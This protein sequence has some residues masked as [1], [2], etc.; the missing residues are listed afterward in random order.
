MYIMVTRAMS[1]N[2]LLLLLGLFLITVVLLIVTLQRGTPEPSLKPQLTKK[3]SGTI[4]PA[5]AKSILT[6]Q[7]NPVTLNANGSGS[8]NVELNTNENAVTAVQLELA[9]DPA[10]LSN[11]TIAAGPFLGKPIELLK[12]IDKSKGTVTLMLGITPAQDPVQ[13][14]GIVA[15]IEFMR[16]GATTEKTTEFQLLNSSLVTASGIDNSVLRSAKGTTVV[17]EQ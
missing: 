15:T 4:V 12:N 14:K 2:V 8:I 9:Y 1:K 5:N 7:P 11:V 6:L 13:G 17:L 3:P 10:V 16:L